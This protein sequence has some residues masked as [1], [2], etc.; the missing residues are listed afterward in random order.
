VVRTDE[1]V[2]VP[3]LRHLLRDLSF[4][5]GATR[6][7]A[8][9]PMELLV[10]RGGL[11]VPLPTRGR[12]RFRRDGLCGSA[13]GGEFYLSEGTSVFHVQADDGRATAR[14]ALGFFAQ[15]FLLRQRFWAFGLLAL[16]RARGLYALHAGAV[17]SPVGAGVLLVG[18]SGSGKSTLTIG[19]LH[20]GWSYLSDDT[21]L[22]RSRPDGIEALALRKPFSVNVDAAAGYA[23]LPLDPEP[24]CTHGIR[25]RRVNMQSAYPRQYRAECR[26]T[27]LLFPRIVAGTRSTVRPLSRAAALGILLA[28]SGPELFDRRSLPGHAEL[29]ARLVRQA[30]SYDLCA[31]TDLH[32]R[33]ALLL[34]LLADGVS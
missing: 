34:D 4:I 14:L 11:S 13:A 7:Q 1:S 8:E 33:P 3:D 18:P 2:D 17:V 24:P 28:Q 26:P 32:T 30:H 6:A 31:G 19:L 22:L 5:E 20:E 9:P 10:E 15:P 29:L 25:K 12:I 16:L 27:M 21:V 23:D